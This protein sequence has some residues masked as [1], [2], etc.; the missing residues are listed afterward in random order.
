MVNLNH[1]FTGLIEQK[2]NAEKAREDC[3]IAK[4]I[5]EEVLNNIPLEKKFYND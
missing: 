1:F 2:K 4:N 3:D 5:K